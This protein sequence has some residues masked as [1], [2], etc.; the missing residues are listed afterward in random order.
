MKNPLLYCVLAGFFFGIW[1]I[2]GRFSKLSPA[3]IAVVVAFATM[4][5]S[6]VNLRALQNIPSFSSLSIG[7]LAGVLNGL[8]L[9]VYGILI[10]WKGQNISKLISIVSVIVPVV[11]IIG[12]YLVFREPIT[13]KKTL[14]IMFACV[15][16]WL[17]SSV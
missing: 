9:L 3:Q 16:I 7:F 2:I 11:I 14:G 10:N 5:V 17:L 4:V 6:L 1:P 8:G 13:I 15:S 12:G